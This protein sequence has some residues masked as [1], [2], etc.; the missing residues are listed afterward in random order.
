MKSVRLRLGEYAA[1]LW[2]VLAAAVFV[3]AGRWETRIRTGGTPYFPFVSVL[4]VTISVGLARVALV[5]L[6]GLLRVGMIL[7]AGRSV[8]T[9]P[10]VRTNLEEVASLKDEMR[11]LRKML[12]FLRDCLPLYCILL[13]YPTS[14][15]LIDAL[16]G[17]RLVD[18]TLVAIDE[19][20]FGGH[21]SV[22]MQQFISPK[23]TDVLSLCY[24]L[25]LA[26]PPLILLVAALHA[27]RG[28]FVEAVEG[29][30]LLSLIGVTLYVIFP[31]IGP[32][33]TL[34][35]LYTR[36]LA[37]GL[38]TTA[39]RAII[40]ATRVP[41][42][43][44]PSLHVAISALLLVYAWRVSRVFAIIV[45]PVILGNWISTIYLRYHYLIDVVAGFALVPP[46]YAAVR[47]WTRR[48]PSSTPIQPFGG[49]CGAQRG[50]EA[51]DRATT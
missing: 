35:H 48:F 10:H 40:D 6:R 11:L 28:L 19:A 23:L 44:F 5:S 46:I 25:H 1:I 45:A 27:P 22:W 30:V 42:D 13:V 12:G 20:V 24:F 2:L 33:H 9:E 31:A 41:R 47:L 17:S 3:G 34:S 49:E 16:Q 18:P 8:W 51:S 4:L 15:F 36:D 21:A 37:G 32:L 38:L 29:F 7:G 14:D 50:G 43:A 39:N 26:I